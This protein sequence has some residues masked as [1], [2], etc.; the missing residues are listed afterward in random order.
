MRPA[1]DE[2]ARDDAIA[3]TKVS[4]NSNQNASTPTSGSA[5]DIHDSTAPATTS[6]LPGERQPVSFATPAGTSCDGRS[7]YAPATRRLNAAADRKHDTTCIIQRTRATCAQAA[8]TD[9]NLRLRVIN[10]P[11]G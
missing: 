5:G 2:R 11:S 3:A 1:L 10:E 4:V 6:S 7:L 8:R 9:A